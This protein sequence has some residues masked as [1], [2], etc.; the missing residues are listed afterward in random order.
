MEFF[1]T[2]WAT[3]WGALAGAVVGAFSAWLFSLDLR[4]RELEAARQRDFDA[5]VAAVVQAFGGLSAAVQAFSFAFLP[6]A[7][8]SVEPPNVARAHLLGAIQVA[9]MTARDD[10]Y[11]P[12]EAAYKVATSIKEGD[13]NRRG[14]EL[15]NAARALMLWKRGKLTTEE[16][17]VQVEFLPQVPPP[18]E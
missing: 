8:V 18:S 10:E 16:A 2:F 17:V 4:K 5:S 9:M 6:N 7:A 12:L 3:M 1:D 13:G 15:D 11:A 14:L